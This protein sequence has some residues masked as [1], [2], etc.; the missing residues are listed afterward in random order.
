M[1]IPVYI[2]NWLQIIENMSTD[3]TYKLAWGRAI[4]ECIHHKKYKEED[5]VIISFDDIADNMI[6][7]YWN[8][9]FFFNLK[10]SG[11][12]KSSPIICQQV[13]LLI[14]RYKEL[15]NSEISVWYD[16]GLKVLKNDD[17]LNK[18]HKKVVKTL[19]ENVSWRFKYVNSEILE[20]Y[21]YNRP[22]SFILID[23]EN[24]TLLNQYNIILSELL[25]FK[26][27]QLLEDYNHQPKIVSKVKGISNT[28]LKRNSLTKYRNILLSQFENGEVFDFYTNECINVEDISIDHVIPWSFMYSDD[29]WNLVITTKSYNSSK[30]NS[31]P[32]EEVIN[33]LKLRNNNLISLLE[34]SNKEDLKYAIDNNLVDKYY[35]DFKV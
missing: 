16:K 10:Q 18:V 22:N 28:T 2:N 15:V 13:T 6:K 24:I 35:Y 7:Y 34:G 20:I 30:S 32:S 9:L 14:N 21:E 5:K 31:I 25:N 19:H 1:D 12:S 3:N 4:L 17:L 27:S 26:W 11:Y 23:K 29:I 8:Q 33:K